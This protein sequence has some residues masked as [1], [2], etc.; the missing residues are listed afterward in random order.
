MKILFVK[1]S[2]FVYEHNEKFIQNIETTFTDVFHHHVILYV[3][4]VI[5]HFF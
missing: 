5:R 1:S 3:G 4:S 2:L